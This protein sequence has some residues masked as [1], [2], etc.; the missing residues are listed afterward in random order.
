MNFTIC[1]GCGADSIGSP[2]SFHI[3]VIGDVS[4]CPLCNGTLVTRKDDT[5]ETVKERLNV[6]KNQT[7]PLVDY[8]GKQG[9]IK[10]INGNLAVEEVFSEIEKALD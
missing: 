5:K 1:I 9:K 8:Y 10:D 6:Y 3:S 7:E 2:A 4:V